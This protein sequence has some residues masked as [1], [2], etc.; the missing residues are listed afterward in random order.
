MTMLQDW[1]ERSISEIATVNPRRDPAIRSMGDQILATFVPMAA[2][3][4][5]SGTIAN[6]EIKTLG[7]IRKGFTSFHENDVLFAKITPCMQN[8]KSAVV[9]GLSN[10]LGFGSTEFHVI[11][12]GPKVLPKWIWYFVRQHSV[13]ER[14][15]QH[16]RGSAGQQ[17]VPADFLKKLKIPVPSIAKQRLVLSRIADCTDRIDEIRELRSE[18]IRE[19]KTIESAMFHDFL[20]DGNKTPRW[21]LVRLGDLTKSSKYGISARAENGQIG[22]PMLRMGNIVDGYLDF[23]DMK[24]LKLPE[25]QKQT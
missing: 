24:Y 25:D 3:D 19:S 1:P 22:I 7:E 17:R 23:S 6:L 4:E 8:G 11:R 10:G 16:F 5:I 2:I 12:P 13:R 15:Q 18:G 9:Q 14:A 20:Y 21:S